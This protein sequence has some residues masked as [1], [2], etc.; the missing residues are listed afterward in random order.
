[1]DDEQKHI[2]GYDGEI[3]LIHETINKDQ[4]EYD[5]QLL[6]LSSGFL[7]VSLAFIKD[8]VPLKD[9]VCI[10]LLYAAYSLLVVCIMLVLASYQYGIKGQYKAKDFWEEKKKCP[11]KSLEDFPFKYATR[12]RW[13]NIITGLVFFVGVSTLALFV[14][15]NIHYMR[16]NVTTEHALANEAAHMKAPTP[17][18]NEDRGSHIKIPARPPATQPSPNPSPNNQPNK[19][20]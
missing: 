12:I 5:K 15:L 19:S 20:K 16:S 14:I 7:A 3:S 8:L 17:G 18:S 1:M 9:A 6:T 4:A 2:D 10:A 13:L 11:E